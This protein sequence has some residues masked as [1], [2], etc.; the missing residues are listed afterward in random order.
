MGFDLSAEI[1]DITALLKYNKTRIDY[2]GGT[3]PI[4]EN[5]DMLIKAAS[6]CRENHVAEHLDA[7]RA[8]IL[9]MSQ[10]PPEPAPIAPI[11]P[12]DLEQFSP[13]RALPALKQLNFMR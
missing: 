2:M 1:I 12:I 8:A 7:I 11:A 13:A 5:I 10:N 6:F 9:R 4:Q 3:M